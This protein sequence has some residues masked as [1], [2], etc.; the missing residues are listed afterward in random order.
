MSRTTIK[1]ML[2]KANK[3]NYAHGAYN[4]YALWRI[5]ALIK[6]HEEKDLSLI[7]QVADP[8]N[9]FSGGKTDF[10]SA[11]TKDRFVGAKR[12]VEK[13]K[14]AASETKIDVCL[15]LDHGKS[16]EA[17]KNAIAAGFT[18]VILTQEYF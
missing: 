2:E 11:T 17:V 18:S 6:A 15:H 5:D 10:M 7:I 13:F 16:L 12:I 9:G 4:V 3:L 14:Q 1:P 8:A